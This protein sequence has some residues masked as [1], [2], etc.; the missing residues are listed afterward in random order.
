MRRTLFPIANTDLQNRGLSND[1]VRRDPFAALQTE[2]NRL[3]DDVWSGFG[4]PAANVQQAIAAPRLDVHEDDANLYVTAE[5]PGLSENDIELSYDDGVL[6]L[7]GEKKVED[8]DNRRAH[9]TERAYGRFERQIPLGR[10]VDEDKIDAAFK[11]GV[12]TITLPKAA[13]KEQ[14]K[15]ISV[16]RAA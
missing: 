6:R 13:E 14:T 1:A 4:T 5:L 15:K 16:K 7:A 8:G 2:M 11:D 9:V 3:F 10:Q 12:L